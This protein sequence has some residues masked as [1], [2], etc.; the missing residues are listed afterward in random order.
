MDYTKIATETS[1]SNTVSALTNH[2]FI[3]VVVESKEEALAKIIELIPNG[4][5]VN[6]GAS[7][8][9][10][11]VG[12]LEYLKKGEHGWNNLHEVILKESDPVKQGL[13][14]KETTTSDY[15][16]GSVHAITET[17]ELVISSATGSQLPGLAYNAQN[18]VLVVGAQKIVPTL[19]DAFSRIETHIIP[20]EDA[21]M[22]AAYGMGTLHAKNPYSSSGTSNDAAKGICDS[23]KRISRFLIS[24]HTKIATPNMW[25][26][27]YV[28]KFQNFHKIW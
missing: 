4:V 24:L 26:F 5:S 7:L 15:Y 25:W 8:T 12:L 6:N 22:K 13:L 2:N 21:R 19:N 20:L 23:C 27:L 9:L 14:R 18:L 28:K 11:Q 16:L 17:G 3:P 1:L 10:E